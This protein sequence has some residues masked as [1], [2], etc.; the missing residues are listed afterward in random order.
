[1]N[2]IEREFNQQSSRKMMIDML[3]NRHNLPLQKEIF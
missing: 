1:M 3:R 2:L